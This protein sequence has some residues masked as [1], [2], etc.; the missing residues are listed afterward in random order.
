MNTHEHFLDMARKLAESKGACGYRMGAIL[1]QKSQIIS[2]GYNRSCGNIPPDIFNTHRKSS[3]L[4][5]LHAEIDAIL[6]VLPGLNAQ[7]DSR[8]KIYVSG[9]SKAGN[10]IIAM[11]CKNCI[12]VLWNCGIKRIYYSTKIG[13]EY[14]R[15]EEYNIDA[16]V[17]REHCSSCDQSLSRLYD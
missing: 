10:P 1:V 2:T 9:I 15:L 14:L 7:L 5:I 11:P 6:G 4:G 12:R 17:R 13:Y 3:L 8:T 16:L